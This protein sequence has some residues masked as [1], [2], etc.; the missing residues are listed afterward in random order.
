M[1]QPCGPLATSVSKEPDTCKFKLDF[2]GRPTLEIK[3]AIFTEKA[4]PVYPSIPC[5]IQRDH[6]PLKLGDLRRRVQKKELFCER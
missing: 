4:V 3:G 2:Q 6:S 5:R 1:L